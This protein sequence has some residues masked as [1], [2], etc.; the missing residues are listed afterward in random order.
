MDT[1]T[2]IYIELIFAGIS[3]LLIYM[4]M[5]IFLKNRREIHFI[6]KLIILLIALFAKFSAS[7]FH[8]ESIIILST[9]SIVSGVVIGKSCFNSKIWV[10]GMAGIFHWLAGASSELLASF[11]ITGIQDMYVSDVMQLNIY[12]IQARTVSCLI[13]LLMVV[14]VNRFRNVN[15]DSI[16]V[17]LTLIFCIPLIGSVFIVQQFMLHITTS[18]TTPTINEVIPLISIMAVN[19]FIFILVENALMQ[20]EREH[21]LFLIKSQNH[22]QQGHIKQL[23]DT[24][25]QIRT[26]THNFKHQVE[27]LYTLC[28]ENRIEDLTSHLSKLSTQGQSIII[29]DTGN[30]MLDAI[31]SS[32]KNE[33]DSQKIDF[34]IDLEVEAALSYMTMDICVLLGNGLDNAIEAC[35][36]ST[37]KNRFVELDL[38]ATSSKFMF[39]IR[40]SIGEKPEIK[41]GLLA[42]KKDNNIVHGIG[43]QSMKQTCHALGGRMTYEF[44]DEH[45][46]LWI[47]IATKS[48]TVIK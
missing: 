38:A 11:I 3:I 21:T 34:R 35:L 29:V 36:R 44:D 40:N 39:R 20:K 5:Q 30:A 7:Y 1:A 42:T 18:V 23:M 15:M 10:V 22:A 46:M 12:R 2:W 41:D 26:M 37:K 9:V 14:L 24:N 31:L 32:K 33:A 19:I 6:W 13:Y 48:L 16:T 45:F 28:R 27:I 47:S 17:K 43:L 4:F 25:M 8:I